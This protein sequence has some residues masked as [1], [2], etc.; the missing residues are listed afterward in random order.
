MLF[1][2]KSVR[3]L[4]PLLEHLPP[5]SDHPDRAS[6][7]RDAFVAHLLAFFD[8]TLRSFPAPEDFSRTRQAKQYLAVD[9]LPRSTPADF[10]RLVDPAVLEPTLAH[11]LRETARRGGEAPA[12]L[13]E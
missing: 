1:G 6:Q 7:T 11:L 3:G 4:L 12:D 9:R 2:S 10:H 8:P 5:L 13:P